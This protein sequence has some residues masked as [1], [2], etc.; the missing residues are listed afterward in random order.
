[1]GVPGR[2]C[3]ILVYTGMCWDTHTGA[4]EGLGGYWEG[5]GGLRKVRD[6]YWSI[7]VD[8]GTLTRMVGW[9]LVVSVLC[10]PGMLPAERP[11]HL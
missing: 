4:G 5:L 1:M 11:S 2:Y 9:V 6:N 10:S 8:T 3:S 7:L